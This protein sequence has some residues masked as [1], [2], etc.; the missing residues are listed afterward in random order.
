MFFFFSFHFQGF[1]ILIHFF[2][3]YL[4]L[5]PPW[6]HTQ[7]DHTTMMTMTT[8]GGREDMRVWGNKPKRRRCTTSLGPWQRTQ[9]NHMTRQQQQ[10]DERVQRFLLPPWQ[11]TQLDHM[12][13][14]TTTTGGREGMRVVQGNKPKRCRTMSLGLQY[15]FFLFC[16]R[17]SNTNTIF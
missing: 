3:Y 15:V 8:T 1:L 7:L 2:K 12:T 9:L 10:A 11:H 6:W 4:L 5:V 17:H 13:T 16:F 14:M